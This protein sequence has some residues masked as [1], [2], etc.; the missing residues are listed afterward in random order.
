MN[1]FAKIDENNIVVD[2]INADESFI[3]SGVVGDFRKWIECKR[4]GS[5]RKNM[6]GIGYTYDETLDAFIPPKFYE[7]W[8]LDENTCQWIPPVAAPD[9]GKLY[10]WNDVNQSWDQ[11]PE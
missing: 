11:V 3:R 2:V 9:D 1:H 7:N 8:I 5:I 10:T 6:P 4:D